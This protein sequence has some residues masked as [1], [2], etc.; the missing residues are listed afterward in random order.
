[1]KRIQRTWARA[2]VML[3]GGLA[4]SGL[5]GGCKP[6]Q[7][8]TPNRTKDM[9]KPMDDAGESCEAV[10][11]E[12]PAGVCCNGE[13]C[14]DTS[15]SPLNC[16]TCGKVCGSREVCANSAC[17]CR[18]GGRDQA[19]GAGTQCCTDG[20]RDVMAD[21]VNCGGCGR[22]CVSGERCEGGSCKCGPAGLSCRSNQTCCTSGCSNL[23]DDPKNCGMCG[24]ECAAGKA[25]K[26]GVCEGE[27][28]APCAL[29]EICCNGSCT[30]LFSD[31]RNCRMCG[32][33][34]R[35]VTGW[36][37]CIGGVCLFEQP[38]DMAVPM[39]MSIPPDMAMSVDMTM[40]RSR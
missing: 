38:P 36:D 2:L 13:P 4:L 22:T 14:V 17:V 18:G 30:N 19:C 32:R 7:A 28:A 29:P 26:A 33:D 8:M 3:V 21:K 10:K 31:P 25:C 1:M 6:D 37:T 20:C 24:K 40:L 5:L 15:T 16:G 11:C 23:V 34:C 9:A 35:M 27:C 39:D 12:N